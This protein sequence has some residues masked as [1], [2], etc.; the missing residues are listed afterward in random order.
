MDVVYKRV[1]HFHGNQFVCEHHQPQ[2]NSRI[3][4]KPILDFLSAK[5]TIK[6]LW[7]VFLS[8][9]KACLDPPEHGTLVFLPVMQVFADKA[10]Y[11]K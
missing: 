3:K 10:H 7:P 2:Y 6:L 11:S 1:G 4:S 9:I 8:T 5:Y